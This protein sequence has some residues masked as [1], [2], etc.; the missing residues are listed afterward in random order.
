M[1]HDRR[2]FLRQGALAAATLTA[3]PFDA[4]RRRA[5]LRAEETRS[6]GYG[7]LRPVR[8]EATGL[9]LLK[10]PE[11]FRYCT[12]S[13]TGD[14]LDDGTPTPDYHDGMAVVAQEGNIVTLI[15][16]HEV[17]K[18]GHSI[19]SAER[20]Y[21]PQAGGGCT[22]L[23]F[24]VKEK[25]LVSSIGAIGGT[26]RN[27]AGGPTP[28]GSWLT[29]EETV[30]AAHGMFDGKRLPF[31]K[32]HGF[33]FEVPAS[34]EGR[35]IPLSAM[36]RFVHEAVAVDPATGIVYETE[37][38]QTAGFYRF[39]PNVPGKLADGGK[40]QMLKVEGKADVRT[41]MTPDATMAC[42]WVDILD[43]LR[44]HAGSGINSLGVYQ[45]GKDQGATTF[46]RLEGCW[47]GGGKIY[48]VST[49]GGDK[50]HGQI[51]EYDPK[52]ERLRLVFES[53][54][55]Q[56]L[57]YPDNITVSPR[58]G[59]V[60]CEDGDRRVERLCGL[61]VDGQIFPLAAN[62]VVLNGER[63]GFSGDFTKQEW[64]GACFS[65]DGEWLFANIQTPG[66]TVAITGP[67][68]RGLL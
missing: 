61:T 67:W 44:P 6:V 20:T 14:P 32:D 52:E 21:D 23:L 18:P 54:D 48:F 27:C 51:F 40:L 13:W 29:C 16:N 9:E 12:F 24:D 15:R 43:P 11:G 28:W 1:S 46:A 19:A 3:A 10:L 7:E 35:P 66:L 62:N 64:C 39:V 26:Q 55:P 22:R 38:Q 56:V 47:Y 33:I 59:L 31:E 53:T 2:D 60:L 36:G 17:F 4:F 65:P 25:K 63:N 30:D 42:S 5:E 50:G 45:Q 49:S 41:R 57:D 34:G 8:D 68:E 58:G 37:D